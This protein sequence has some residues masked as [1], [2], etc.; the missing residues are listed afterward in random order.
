VAGSLAGDQDDA[1]GEQRLEE[2]RVPLRER[3]RSLPDI[4]VILS[5]ATPRLPATKSPSLPTGSWLSDSPS[6]SFVLANVGIGEP[7]A[8]S[9]FPE[10][11]LV[12]RALED[13]RRRAGAVSA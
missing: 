2:R 5:A 6:P 9:F 3:L 12:E 1:G 7:I 8:R 10:V 11:P 13:L 4:Q